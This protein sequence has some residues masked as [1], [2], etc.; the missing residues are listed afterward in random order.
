MQRKHS[1]AAG[2][3]LVH[4]ASNIH[5]ATVER[6]LPTNIELYRSEG[7]TPVLSDFSLRAAS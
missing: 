2:S 3:A 7:S 1:R 6:W 5:I 4:H